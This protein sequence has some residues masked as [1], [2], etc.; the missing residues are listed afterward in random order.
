M[1]S[2]LEKASLLKES[3]KKLLDSKK[4]VEELSKFGHV[5]FTGS[6]A[7]DLMVWPDIDMQVEI[8]AN[9]HDRI[10]V[11]SDLAYKFLQDSDFKNVKL[12][13]FTPGKKPGMPTGMY[14]GLT[15]KHNGQSWKIDIWALDPEHIHNNV[16][17]MNQVELKL[18]KNLK[19]FIIDW[20]HK[21]LRDG[22]IPQFGSYMLY[23]A[24]LF[25][26]M[27]GDDEI[28]KYLTENGV[29]L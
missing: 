24:V 14:M 28:L 8:D 22:R 29:K 7:L 3:G 2:H 4:I 23:K 11:F 1:S 19:E 20:K 15:C 27:K 6:Y 25:E 13:N 18:T 17:Y 5:K 9:T 26:G 16:N 12:I 21:L 10:R